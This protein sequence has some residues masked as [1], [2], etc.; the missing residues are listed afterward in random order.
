MRLFSTGYTCS[1]FVHIRVKSAAGSSGDQREMPGIRFGMASNDGS[2]FA[3]FRRGTSPGRFAS[4]DLYPVYS[5]CT[6]RPP[7]GISRDVCGYLTRENN[8]RGYIVFARV[9]LAYTIEFGE[10][11]RHLFSS[12]ERWATDIARRKR[13]LKSRL[14]DFHG[15]RGSERSGLQSVKE[16]DKRSSFRTCIF[17]DN[18][19][20][21]KKKRILLV[22]YFTTLRH[23]LSYADRYSF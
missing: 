12:R 13:I 1:R 7:P 10:R 21:K 17:V 15:I 18:K 8:L 6:S 2:W 19:K 4:C 9:Y 5:S 3:A 23:F 14:N 11:G 20:K 22:F 16:T